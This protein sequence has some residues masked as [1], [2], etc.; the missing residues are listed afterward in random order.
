[1]RLLTRFDFDGVCCAVL[2]RELEVVDEI[3]FIHPK[4]LQDGNF[5]VTK[6][7]V[8]ANVA[9]VEGCGLWFDHH[10]SE[11]ERQELE[12]KFEGA[13]RLELSAARV[14][15]DYYDGSNKLSRFDEMMEQVDIADSGRF[16][17]DDILNPEGWILLSFLCD[18]RTGLAYYDNYKISH[19][20]FMHQLIDKML[21]VSSIDDL[22]EWEHC[23]ERVERYFKQDA[24]FRKYLLENSEMKGPLVITDSRNHDETPPGNRFLIYSLFPDAN[25]SIRLIDG[26][27][28]KNIVVS[29]GHSILNKTST[30][31]VG[32]LMLRYGGGGHYKV[33]TCQVPPEIVDKVIKDMFDEIDS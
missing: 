33:G 29:M 3:K 18:P 8:L 26:K 4:E 24:V 19:F 32:S 13:S 25:I 21:E 22:L 30:V 9:F 17:K 5:A 14:V 12:G 31:N 7:D 20:D 16:T 2:L 15:Y 27:G 6:N 23:K 11:Q 10:S 28:K 1:M